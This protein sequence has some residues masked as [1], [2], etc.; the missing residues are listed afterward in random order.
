MHL[1]PK[2]FLICICEFVKVS[3]FYWRRQWQP[4][5]VF[6]PGEFQGWGNLVGFH[7]WGHTELDMTSSNSPQAINVFIEGCNPQ[8]ST[9]LRGY[10]FLLGNQVGSWRTM[11]TGSAWWVH[12]GVPWSHTWGSILSFHSF[13]SLSIGEGAMG[14]SVVTRSC[15]ALGAEKLPSTRVV[16]SLVSIS[17]PSKGEGHSGTTRNLWKNIYPSQQQRSAW[18]NLLEVASK[19]YRFGRRFWS[20]RSRQSR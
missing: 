9:L 13:W 16:P 4:T 17:L 5:P 12:P 2:D 1:V 20:R 18:V 8:Q 11:M 10:F 3:A 14:S 15:R 19:W 6:L 7:L